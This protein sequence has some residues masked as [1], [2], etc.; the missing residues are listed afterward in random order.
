MPHLQTVR[1]GAPAEAGAAHTWMTVPS[2]PSRRNTQARLAM[3]AAL[4]CLTTMASVAAEISS[5]FRT[6]SA[7]V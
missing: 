6:A 5:E 2:R 7:L 3:T 1:A 4:T